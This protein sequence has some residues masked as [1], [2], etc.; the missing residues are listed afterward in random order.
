V[1]TRFPLIAVIGL[2]VLEKPEGARY[3]SHFRRAKVVALGHVD[4]IDFE[5]IDDLKDL[6][7]VSILLARDKD[8]RLFS[9]ENLSRVSN[10]QGQV[11]R[12]ITEIN[13]GDIVINH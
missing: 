6:E 13:V 1:S 7:Q 4:N 8:L 3:L 10:I 9:G 11:S 5:G 12:F 2:F